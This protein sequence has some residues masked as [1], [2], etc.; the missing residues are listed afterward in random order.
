[1]YQI[2]TWLAQLGGAAVRDLRL[3]CVHRNKLIRECLVS[4]MRAGGCDAREVDHDRW[5][6]CQEI[7]K[8]RPHV[9][10]V[11]L[12]LPQ[13]S[14]LE[15]VKHVRAFLKE[16]KI[17]VLIPCKSLSA[18]DRQKV[19]ESVG[20][21][22]HGFVLEESSLDELRDAIGHAMEGRMFCSPHIV[23]SMFADL[24][25]LTREASWSGRTRTSKLTRREL[26]VLKW[27]AE[28]LSNKQVAGR[29]SLSIYTIKNHIHNIL[30]KL[31]VED[32]LAAVEH[33]VDQEWITP[34]NGYVVAQR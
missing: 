5:N 3:G 10:V 34:V 1:M 9:V 22:V 2:A 21:G 7:E 13:R 24:A 31:E 30:K 14:S 33:A 11:D 17:I 18:Y 29:L 16:V 6:H 25:S 12:G 19:L 23:G 20:L 32:R 27:V 8:F 4:A 15:I 28:G 26:E